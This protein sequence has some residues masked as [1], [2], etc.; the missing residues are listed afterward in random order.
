VSS[1]R[2]FRVRWTRVAAQDL[3]AI[4]DYLASENP[5]AAMDVLDALQASARSLE[6][7]PERGRIVPELRDQ[8]I[9]TWRELIEAPWRVLYRID[10]GS[11]WI[12]AVIDGRRNVEDVL[13]QRLMR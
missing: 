9:D 12:L 6:S 3:Q 10:E 1:G 11:V 5:T 7:M 4:V 2:A 8:G 13:L